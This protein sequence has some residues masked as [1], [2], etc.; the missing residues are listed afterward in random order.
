[1]GRMLLI[2]KELENQTNVHLG[3]NAHEVGLIIGQ[4]SEIRDYAIHLARCPDPEDDAVEVEVGEDGNNTTPSPPTRSGQRNA[5]AGIDSKWIVEHARQVNRML[6]G[7]LS[8][9]GVYMIATAEVF[10]QSQ[11]KL[12]QC[13]HIIQKKIENSKVL[14]NKHMVHQDKYLLH[15][16]QASRRFT[17]RSIDASDDQSSL[18]PVEFRVQSFLENWKSV[19]ACVDI[20]VQSFVPMNQEVLR[21][22]QKIVYA[23][24]KE[25]DRIW[26]SRAVSGYKVID[27][28][29][30]LV[31]ETKGKSK[32]SQVDDIKISLFKDSNG[33]TN[34][35]HVATDSVGS[36]VKFVGSIVAKAFLHPKSTYGDA[37]RALKTDAVR[38]LLTRIELLSEETEVNNLCQQNEWSLLSPARVFGAFKKYNISFCDYLFKDESEMDS[39]RR[40]SE[41]LNIPG[42]Q[43]DFPEQSPDASVAS[44]LLLGEKSVDH[45]SDVAS[46][47]SINCIEEP[48]DKK[49]VAIGVA[50]LTALLAVTVHLLST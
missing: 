31:V 14:K 26:N 5:E 17:C 9:V 45:L 38:S 27:E 19:E 33:L 10:T 46:E 37:I 13:L 34:K 22:Q 4:L 35:L 43:L 50:A 49:I 30:P 18:K 44:M 3:S 32:S 48:R 47:I 11:T 15:I 41:L 7:G 24:Q 6:T 25:I 8:V 12:K 21:T 23:C 36:Q 20:N 40:F 29:K 16:C 42:C 39:I 2:E 1:M 28:K